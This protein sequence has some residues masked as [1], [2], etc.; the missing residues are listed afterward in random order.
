MKKRVMLLLT[1]P[2]PALTWAVEGT[3]TLVE[4]IDTPF[5]FD[6]GIHHLF[7][8]KCQELGTFNK[9]MLLVAM[10]AIRTFSFNTIIDIKGVHF[11]LRLELE[12]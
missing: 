9:K 5:I 10:I 6:D 11:L 2:T 4:T 8:I 7:L 3:M 12:A 1:G